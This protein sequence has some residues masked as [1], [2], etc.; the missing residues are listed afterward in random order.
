MP[1]TL[2]FHPADFRPS[3]GPASLPLPYTVKIANSINAYWV[4]Q[5]QVKTYL[6][7]N[8]LLIIHI[9]ITLLF[10]NFLT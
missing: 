10:Q 6:I 9:T 7:Q 4:Y 1:T 5:I 8:L 3:Y 2:L